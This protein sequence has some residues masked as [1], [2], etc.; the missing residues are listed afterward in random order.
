MT[1]QRGIREKKNNTYPM[2]GFRRDFSKILMSRE[3]SDLEKPCQSF[4]RESE[5]N[6]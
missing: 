3:Q 6:T 1:K 4:L 5:S 2:P